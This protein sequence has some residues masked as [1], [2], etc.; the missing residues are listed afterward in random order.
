MCRQSEKNWLNGNIFS[1][2]HTM[3]NV[4]PVTAEIDWRVWGTLA[5]FNGFRVLASLLHRRR[6]P[7]A[8]QTLHDLWPSPGLVH[9]VYTLSG[10]CPVTE[11]C[12]PKFTLRWS[13]GFSYIGSVIARH[14]SSGV[15]QTL[16]HGTRNGIMELSHRTPPIFGWAAITLGIGPHSSL[17][18]HLVLLMS[19]FDLM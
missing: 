3:A 15:S 18:L 1:S 9:C 19:T 17:M 8:N 14:S 4:G 16:R 7:E 12:H 2:V 13:L 11:F 6:S 10:A 5:N